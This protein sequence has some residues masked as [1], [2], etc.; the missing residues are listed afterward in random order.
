MTCV[1]SIQT[2][3]VQRKATNSSNF[4]TASMNYCFSHSFNEQHSKYT[5]TPSVGVST[6][7]NRGTIVAL[8][9][10]RT[11]HLLLKTLL[12]RFSLAVMQFD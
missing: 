3:Q 9:P 2:Y 8:Q 1:R 10:C 6:K 5:P 12:S 7:A 4:A 11:D